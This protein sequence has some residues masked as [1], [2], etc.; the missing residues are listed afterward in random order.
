M[1]LP[2]IVFWAFAIII[3]IILLKIVFAITWWFLSFSIPFGLIIL[4][5][6]AY[7]FLKS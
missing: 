6:I 3:A 4:G 7:R 5:Y 1:T 2:Q